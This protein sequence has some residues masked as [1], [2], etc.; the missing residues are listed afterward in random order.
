MSDFAREHAHQD[1]IDTSHAAAERAESMADRHK[2]LVYAALKTGPLAS[3]QIARI[4]G[5]NALQVMKR[6]SDLRNEDAV[7]DSGE[8]RPTVSGRMA[9]VWKLKPMQLAL[10]L[11][12]AE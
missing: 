2:A 8:R 12:A 10:S 1:D 6:I 7:I 5:L 3:E 11:E 9:A 4:T